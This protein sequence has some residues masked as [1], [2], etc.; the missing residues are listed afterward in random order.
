MK[1]M[2]APIAFAL[3]AFSA[4]AFAQEADTR[5]ARGEAA[6]NA[7][8]GGNGLPPHFLQLEKEF[9]ELAA[10][11]RDYALGDVWGRT[12]FDPKTRQL[13]S[14]AGFAAEGHLAHFKVHATYALDMGA[15]PAELMEVVYITTVTSGFP[16]ALTAAAALK[17]LFQEKGIALPVSAQ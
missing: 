16:R 13:V 6:L 14:L 9:P 7:L 1:S 15:T 10:L 5:K 17:E 4:P 12:V 11:T 3:A 8:T 2:L